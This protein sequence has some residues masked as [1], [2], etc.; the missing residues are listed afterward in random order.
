MLNASF[1]AIEEKDVPVIRAWL[2]SLAERREEL[3]ESYRQQG[4]RHELF[5][6][7]RA[8]DPVLVLISELDDVEQGSV[9]F[10][11]SRLPL[12]L[13]FKSLV[14]TVSNGEMLVGELLFDSASLLGAGRADGRDTAKA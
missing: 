12:D 14:Q 10:L 4:T 2:A 9:T 5:F 8:P 3:R 6:V 7:V 1:A 13:E 11:G